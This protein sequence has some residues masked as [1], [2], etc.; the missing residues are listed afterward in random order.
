MMKK[1]PL[2]L[3][4]TLMLQSIFASAD[5]ASLIDRTVIMK[6]M[7]ALDKANSSNIK[8]GVL[9]S[10]WST[11]RVNRTSLGDYTT[12]TFADNYYDPRASDPS[13]ISDAPQISCMFSDSGDIAYLTSPEESG[14]SERM[15]DLV[16]PDI[17]YQERIFENLVSSIRSGIDVY[18]YDSIY[19]I[20]GDKITKIGDTR[21]QKADPEDY[22]YD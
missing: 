12:V 7:A 10:R 22:L 9:I 14:G 19:Q 15:I 6:C 13:F 4:V 8:D 3:L 18:A 11:V 16:C 21:V 2:S 17:E 20:T 1:I 5:D